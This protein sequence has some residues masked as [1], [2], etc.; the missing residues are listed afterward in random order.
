MPGGLEAG[1]SPVKGQDAPVTACG[2]TP[3]GHGRAK[4]TG[5]ARDPRNWR[6]IRA[7]RHPRERGRRVKLKARWPRLYGSGPIR[8][9]P[10]ATTLSWYSQRHTTRTRALPFLCACRVAYG[11]VPTTGDGSTRVAIAPRPVGRGPRRPLDRDPRDDRFVR[12]RRAGAS[13]DTATDVRSEGRQEP[14]IGS[15]STWERRSTYQTILVP[16]FSVLSKTIRPSQMAI[17]GNTVRPKSV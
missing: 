13:E 5:P 17:S 4:L 15:G 7:R 16:D 2:I 14:C 12:L 6:S 10:P 9:E 1:A 11:G 3:S 8:R